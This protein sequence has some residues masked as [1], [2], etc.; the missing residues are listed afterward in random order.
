MRIAQLK[1]MVTLARTDPRTHKLFVLALR[2]CGCAHPRTRHSTRSLGV[3]DIGLCL[4]LKTTSNKI[5][6]TALTNV[7]TN[8][9]SLYS[10]GVQ[11]LLRL[12]SSSHLFSS[13]ARVATIMSP[14]TSRWM[15][16]SSSR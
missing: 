1:M 6:T 11:V 13:T 14:R 5:P 12:G 4:K 7:W 3:L 8:T 9:L 10:L 16:I 2:L 15:R